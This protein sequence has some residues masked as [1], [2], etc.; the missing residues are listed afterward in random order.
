MKLGNLLAWNKIDTAQ[1]SINVGDSLTLIAPPRT[2]A[3]ASVSRRAAAVQASLAAEPP[4]ST[5][6]SDAAGKRFYTVKRGD[7]LFSIS[8]KFALPLPDD[9]VLQ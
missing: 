9:P 1:P 7:N 8:R 2:L 6:K 5:E 4:R 3:S